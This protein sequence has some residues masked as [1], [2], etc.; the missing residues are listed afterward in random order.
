MMFPQ[1]GI[2]FWPYGASVIPRISSSREMAS[3][4]SREFSYLQGSI[5]N[6]SVPFLPPLCFTKVQPLLT[7]EYRQWECTELP[8]PTHRTRPKNTYIS[9]PGPNKTTHLDSSSLLTLSAF[10]SFSSSPR[11]RVARGECHEGA[12][13][14]E[15]PRLTR[16][17]K[18]CFAASFGN[19]YRPQLH[20]MPTIE[21]RKGC[22]FHTGL[23]VAEQFVQQVSTTHL[24]V[25]CFG[26]CISTRITVLSTSPRHHLM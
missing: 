26:R 21:W 20:C 6:D 13:S 12:K 10:L 9:T 2:R 14:R 16:E 7:L 18:F 25:N 8:S 1:G 23:R 17:P 5:K 24:P 19:S 4:Q 22:F 15:S 3:G 11:T